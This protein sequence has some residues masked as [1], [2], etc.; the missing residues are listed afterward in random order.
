MACVKFPKKG[1]E[2]RVCNLDPRDKRHWSDATF[3]KYD[4]TTPSRPYQCINPFGHTEGFRF[5]EYKQG[6]L[7][8]KQPIGLE[9]KKIH[10]KKR[11]RQIVAAI[12]RYLS[13]DLYIPKEWIYELNRLNRL[14]QED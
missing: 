4:A 2:V 6:P 12:E 11:M 7:K 10:D 9:P 13:A 8:T 3:I 14:M 1:E 5:C